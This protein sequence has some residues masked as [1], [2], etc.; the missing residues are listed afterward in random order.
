[1]R[2][3]YLILRRKCNYKLH[4]QWYTAWC[5]NHRFLQTEVLQA[6]W[7]FGNE[8]I[9]NTASSMFRN[10]MTNADQP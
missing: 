4:T 3:I 8:D 9:G 10:W 5:I 7:R 2:Q 6:G 1:M